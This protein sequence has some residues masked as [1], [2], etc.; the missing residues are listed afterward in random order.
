MVLVG[1]NSYLDVERLGSFVLRNY[2]EAM[3]FLALL[4]YEMAHRYLYLPEKALVI[5]QVHSKS[6]K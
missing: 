2:V 6:S 5:R 3:V 1:P 4:V